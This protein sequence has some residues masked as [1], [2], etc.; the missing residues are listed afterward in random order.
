MKSQ[1]RAHAATACFPGL[2]FFG[3][4][5]KFAQGVVEPHLGSVS[6]EHC[7]LC[8][9]SF[10]VLSDSRIDEIKSKF[11]G[12][13]FRLHANV[14]LPEFGRV[15]LDASTY[16][17][18]T[19][20]YYEALARASQRLG[21]NAYTLHAGRRANCSLEEMGNNVR[22]I[23]DLFGMRV[24]VEGLYPSRDGEWL[25]A[26]WSDYQWLLNSG[27]DFAL[28]LSHLN[29]VAKRARTREPSLVGELL[30]SEH[31]IEIHCSSNNGVRD[32]HAVTTPDDWW[33]SMLNGSIPVNSG[34]VVFT[35]GNQ[36]RQAVPP[37]AVHRAD[38]QR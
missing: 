11:P 34:A 3:A 25:L 19:R 29:I 27:L 30:A 6:F 18:N 1:L 9:Q 37:L 33:L 31:C 15:L 23:R 17:I 5:E 28:D 16:R 24:G 7:Q 13:Q 2:P 8:P 35:E 38:V 26:D 12:T 10:G 22:E 32:S 14:H 4:L 20:P 36:Y 21:A